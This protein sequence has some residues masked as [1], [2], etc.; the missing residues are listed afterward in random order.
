[1]TSDPPPAL[2]VID[3]QEG[4][5]E[6]P[7]PRNN[8]TA[9]QQM[10]ALLE[11]WRRAK[12]PVIHVQHMARDPGSPLRPD[13]PGNAI[14]AIVRPAPGEPLFQK[15]VNS[16]FIG[17]SLERYLRQRS[18]ARLVLVGLTTDQCVSTTARMASNLGFHVVVVDDATATFDRTGPDGVQ[19]AAEQMHR[20]E[21]A[22]LHQ[23]FAQVVRAGELLAQLGLRAAV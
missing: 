1:M 9:E 17:T 11:A 8:P 18:I 4:M 12:W 3:V 21:L 2:V 13:R 14:K 15:T 10:A 23:E 7:L 6:V 5:D 19:Y 20:V 22:S 16:A